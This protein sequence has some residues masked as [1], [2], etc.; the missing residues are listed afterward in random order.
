GH[1]SRLVGHP[2][3]LCRPPMGGVIEFT[4]VRRPRCHPT[5]ADEVTDA[6]NARAQTASQV[7][8]ALLPGLHPASSSPA[9]SSTSHM[10]AKAQ[11]Q[12]CMVLVRGSGRNPG[13]LAPC[14][15]AGFSR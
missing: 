10:V 14:P 3:R 12:S 4:V 1:P 7:G 2:T 5:A 6:L 9:P 13:S 15:T 8:P 11:L